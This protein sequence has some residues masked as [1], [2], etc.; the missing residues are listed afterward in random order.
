MHDEFMRQAL[1]LAREAASQAKRRPG[2]VARTNLKLPREP[3]PER[4]IASDL[5][6]SAVGFCEETHCPVSDAPGGLVVLRA[7]PWRQE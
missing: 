1:E 5:N 7:V 6:R 3:V 4:G 2:P